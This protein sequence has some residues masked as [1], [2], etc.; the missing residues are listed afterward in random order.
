MH[1][2]LLLPSLGRG[3]VRGLR[4]VRSFNSDR[5]LHLDFY[6]A[7]SQFSILTYLFSSEGWADFQRLEGA[8][9]LCLDGS[10]VSGMK[11]YEVFSTLR[12][13]LIKRYEFEP[14]AFLGGAKHAFSQVSESTLMYSCSRK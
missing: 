10:F 11:T 5:D 3:G 9:V 13:P 1:R 2:L 8:G 14:V 4:T 7:K 6:T 12:H